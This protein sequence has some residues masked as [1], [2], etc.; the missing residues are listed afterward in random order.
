[1]RRFPN[2][3][4]LVA[5]S[6]AGN[7]LGGETITVDGTTHRNAEFAEVCREGLVYQTEEGGYLTLPWSATTPGQL[8]G[9]RTKMPAA[10]DN[11]L[12][13][14]HYV[15]GT[16][17]Q[18]SS[19]GVIIQI[20]LPEKQREVGYKNGAKVLESGL[21]LVK[22]LPT[23]IPQGEGAEIEIVAH[24][25]GTFTY[26]LGVAVKEIP[27]L[28]VA[29]PIWS[30]EQEWKNTGGQAMHARLVAVKDGKGMFEKGGQRFVYDLTQLDEDGRKR[31]AEI[32]GKLAGFP[33]P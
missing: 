25:Q 21:V 19:D 7:S 16:V 27:L 4:A 1:M 30:R 2:F 23:S 14:A 33:L 5:V 20:D 10:F 24:K 29:R 22:D 28:T 17:F 6:F 8:S 11:A 12:Y 3:L 15:K 18:V 13:D 9:A 31:A 26:D 32:A